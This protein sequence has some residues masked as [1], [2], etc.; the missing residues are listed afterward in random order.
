MP[1]PTVLKSAFN[2]LAAN[3]DDKWPW[4]LWLRRY[5][6]RRQLW[7]LFLNDPELLLRDLGLNAKAVQAEC[8]K[9]FWQG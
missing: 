5:Q 7:A 9:W 2:V 1:Q 4:R 3:V 8:K 6:T